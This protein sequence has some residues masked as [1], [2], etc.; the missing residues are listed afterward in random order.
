M[1]VWVLGVGIGLVSVFFAFIAENKLHWDQSQHNCDGWTGSAFLVNCVSFGSVVVSAI[2]YLG[3]IAKMRWQ[4]VISGGTRKRTVYRAQ[5]L[6]LVNSAVMALPCFWTFSRDT[7]LADGGDADLLYSFVICPLSA[8]GGLGDAL[9]YLDLIRSTRR[10]V[11]RMTGGSY[12][13]AFGGCEVI[14]VTFAQEDALATAEQG[15]AA[16]ECK[17]AM[18]SL[19]VG[20]VVRVIGDAGLLITGATSVA[21]LRCGPN[22]DMIDV[23]CCYFDDPSCISQFRLRPTQVNAGGDEEAE[24]QSAASYNT[25]AM[26]LRDSLYAQRSSIQRSRMTR[27]Q[28]KKVRWMKAMCSGIVCSLWS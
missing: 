10:A 1:V 26:S 21:A 14:D 23:D 17:S 16:I 24:G 28:A 25:A 27:Q 15:I 11:R 8:A 4:T 6:L 7:L 13:V 22:S 2:F 9:I 5:R 20:Q 19:E 18:D 3:G 12:P